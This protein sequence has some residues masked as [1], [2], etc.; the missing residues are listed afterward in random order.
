MKIEIRNEL[1]GTTTLTLAEQDLVLHRD[2][3]RSPRRGNACRT[4]LEYSDTCR[5]NPALRS[6]RRRA[7]IHPLLGERAGVR[8]DIKPFVVFLLAI[9]FCLST[10]FCSYAQSYSIDW[11][12]VSGGGGTSTGGV[13]SVSGTIGQPDAGGPMTGGNYSV[14]GGFWSL[15]SVVQT[16]GA[17]LLSVMRTTTN[18]V[19]VSWASPSTGF[20]LEVNTNSVASVNWSNAPGT[21][22]DNGAIKYVIVNPPTGNRFYR[23]F[24]P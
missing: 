10:A 14:T 23:L 18:T 1:V 17:P 7:M 3:V 4:V 24:K 16:P 21:I 2:F 22:Q 15:F 5:A 8:E 20:N 12:K 9:V 19:L 11:Y 6:A 13:Y